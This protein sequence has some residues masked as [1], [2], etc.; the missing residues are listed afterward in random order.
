MATN[1]QQ[2]TRSAVSVAPIA[3]CSSSLLGNASKNRIYRRPICIGSIM[4]DGALVERKGAEIVAFTTATVRK[5][6]F[7]EREKKTKRK[8]EQQQ[9][10]WTSFLGYKKK[11]KST[12]CKNETSRR[13]LLPRPSR[14]Q[15]NNNNNNNKT[16]RISRRRLIVKRI[17]PT[18]KLIGT[19]LCR[20]LRRFRCESIRKSI[21]SLSLSLRNQV[22]THLSTIVPRVNNGKVVAGRN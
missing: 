16:M 1:H 12:A 2:F 22:G 21:G 13:S 4:D 10:K 9:P 8:N 11:E 18:E 3:T 6:N 14:N 19:S 20:F 5:L 7:T 15:E 17:R